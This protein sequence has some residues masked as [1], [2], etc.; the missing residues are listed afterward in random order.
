MRYLHETSQG[1]FMAVVLIAYS[2][3]VLYLPRRFASR[4]NLN[5][6]PR[7]LLADGYESGAR[8]GRPVSGVP[9]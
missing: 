3:A 4:G 6:P 7:T 2:V 1:L 8:H 5:R 9:P